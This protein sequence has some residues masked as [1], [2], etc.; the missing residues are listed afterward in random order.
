MD[1]VSSVV[2]A[3]TE[4]N[5]DVIVVIVIVTLVRCLYLDLVFNICC[6][7]FKRMS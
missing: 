3:E 5:I 4:E 6:S 2:T 7:S 1:G